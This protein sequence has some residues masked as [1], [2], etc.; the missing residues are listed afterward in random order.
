MQLNTDGVQRRLCVLSEAVNST[1][2]TA[3]AAPWGRRWCLWLHGDPGGLLLQARG[4]AAAPKVPSLQQALGG[5]TNYGPFVYDKNTD[6][7]YQAVA[8]QY[9][10]EGDRAARNALAAAA[11]RSG[12]ANSSAAIAASQQAQNAYG[13]ALSDRVA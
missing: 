8:Q 5:V 7:V 9:R 11:T 4:G 6:P 2:A 10:R 1:L 12:G 13:A 3:A